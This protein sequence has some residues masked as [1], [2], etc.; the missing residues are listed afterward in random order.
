MCP[1][2]NCRMPEPNFNFQYNGNV[3]INIF[4]S[5]LR[6]DAS[7]ELPK[8][9][10]RHASFAFIL[11][12]LLQFLGFKY[13][14]KTEEPFEA[15]PGIMS[16]SITSLLIYCFSYFIKQKISSSDCFPPLYANVVDGS[17][18]ISCP[19]SLASLSSLLL[20]SSIG[21][22]LPMLALLLALSHQPI[23]WKFL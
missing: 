1:F 8:S 15:R 10:N 13:Q 14:G 22:A 2:S 12:V 16:V 7:S 6:K 3:T 23:L 5:D 11:Q 19:L 18:V 20:P 17:M 9:D 21:P 4:N